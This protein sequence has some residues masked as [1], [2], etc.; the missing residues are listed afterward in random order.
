MHLLWPASDQEKQQLENACI[1]VR[2]IIKD[3]LNWNFVLSAKARQHFVHK[4][5]PKEQEKGAK[6]CANIRPFFKSRS[7]NYQLKKKEK[8]RGLLHICRV[9][10]LKVAFFQGW[11]F[12]Q[13]KLY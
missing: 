10:N 2:R 9:S 5:I 3:K 7:S 1:D 13:F 8:E 4:I 11:I 6:K 12:N